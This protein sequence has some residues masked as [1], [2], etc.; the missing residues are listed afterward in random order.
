[1]LDVRNTAG[2][3]LWVFNTILTDG[4]FDSGNFGAN[5]RNNVWSTCIMTS[6]GFRR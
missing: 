3:E 1:M 4:A 2:R 5:K 6:D